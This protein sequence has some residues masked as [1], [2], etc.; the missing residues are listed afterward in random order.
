MVSSVGA[1]GIALRHGDSLNSGSVLFYCALVLTVALCWVVWWQQPEWSAA[2]RDAAPSWCSASEDLDTAPQW[3]KSLA[4][5]RK[6]LLTTGLLAI[7]LSMLQHLGL[8]IYQEV[9][10]HHFNHFSKGFGIFVRINGYL[11]L[12]GILASLL[13]RGMMRLPLFLASITLLFYWAV[14]RLA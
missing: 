8:V 4:K 10:F 9:L 2:I 3:R 11:V 5:C 7:S 12:F 14:T 13:G 1:S 6:A